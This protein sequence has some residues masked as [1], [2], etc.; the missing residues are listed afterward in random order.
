YYKN[1]I[2]HFFV[3]ISFIATSI[4]A[5]REDMIFLKRIMED[6]NFFKHLFRHE[7]IFDDQI[8]DEDEVTPVLNFLEERG[9]IR[10]GGTAGPAGLEVTG[11]GRSD[12]KPFSGLINNYIE[13]Y[14]VVVRGCTYL[15]KGGKSERDWHKKIRQ[16]GER[17]FKKGEIQRA[18][19]LSQANYQNAI[20]YLLDAEVIQVSEGRE[21]GEKRTVKTYSMSEKRGALEAIRRRLFR[22][23]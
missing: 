6:Y 12:L 13:S 17:M 21:K 11:R 10:R 2:L 5:H 9:W 23:L 8:R 15:R 4:L 14:W 19:A 1:N 16:F 7:F 22:F 3:P 20:R 18:E